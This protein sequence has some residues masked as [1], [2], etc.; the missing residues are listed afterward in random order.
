VRGTIDVEG[1][2]LQPLYTTERPLRLQQLDDTPYRAELR[3]EH[4]RVLAGNGLVP[5][6]EQHTAVEPPFGFLLVLPWDD[7]ARRLVVI[8]G[9]QE[10]VGLDIPSAAPTLSRPVVQVEGGEAAIHWTADHADG[11]ALRYMVRTAAD[12]R[13][14]WRFAA[15]D[16]DRTDWRLPLASLPATPSCRV[17]IGASV[18][19]RTVWMESEPF[20]VPPS[21]PEL[22]VIA[23]ADRA[24]LPPQT[25]ASLRAEAVSVTTGT[26][27]DEA[28]RWHSSLDGELGRGRTLRVVLSPGQHVLT[29]TALAPDGG[30]AQAQVRV[31]VAKARRP[32]RRPS[33]KA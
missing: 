5:L 27:T 17:Q 22:A 13:R 1:V 9:D 29:V 31:S 10:L 25:E 21:P 33:T 12:E 15:C 24:K 8:Q 32:A 16:L 4:G 23:P 14:Q 28:L 2:T 6:A 26:L 20:S 7:R 3:D 18:A 19:G 30:E 11:Q